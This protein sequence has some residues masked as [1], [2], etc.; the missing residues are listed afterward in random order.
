MMISDKDFDAMMNSYAVPALNPDIVT[1]GIH[2]AINQPQSLYPARRKTRS[3]LFSFPAFMLGGA[4]AVAAMIFLALPMAGLQITA[5]SD[6]FDSAIRD[7][8]HSERMAENEVRS[9]DEIFG[10]LEAA[11]SGDQQQ[12]DDL[13]RDQPDDS[14]IWDRF[15]GRS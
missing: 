15:M 2:A 1:Q 14:P 9:A 13:L 8:T 10:M 3:P 7:L 4:V 5:A 11:D 12:L 6:D